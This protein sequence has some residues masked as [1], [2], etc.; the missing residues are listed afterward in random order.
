MEKRIGDLTMY[1]YE[2]VHGDDAEFSVSATG[3]GRH[4]RGGWSQARPIAI[5]RERALTPSIG[6]ISN[7]CSPVRR[8]W[9]RTGLRFAV[10]SWQTASVIRHRSVILTVNGSLLVPVYRHRKDVSDSARGLDYAGLSRIDLKL[11]P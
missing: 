5:K 3:F 11:L 7:D 10:P 9:R 6:R 4:S 1:R 8:H 2:L